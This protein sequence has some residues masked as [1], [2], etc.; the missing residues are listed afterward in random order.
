MPVDRSFGVVP[1]READGLREFLLVR[2]K[3]GHWAFPKGHPHEGEAPTQTARR[4]FKEETGLDLAE[5]IERPSFDEQYEFTKR[6]S[7]KTVRKTVTYFLGRV[8]DGE[9][10]HCPDEIIDTAWGDAE[11]TRGRITFPEGRV[12]FDHVLAILDQ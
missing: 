2:H 4:E 11:L 5:L 9:V 12:L 8:I 3:A 10:R 7:G 6:K 1:Y